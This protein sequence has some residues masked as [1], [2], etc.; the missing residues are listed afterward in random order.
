MRFRPFFDNKNNP[1]KVRVG[2]PADVTPPAPRL[3]N[4]D[5]AV[6]ELCG[7]IGSKVSPRAF[8]QMMRAHPKVLKAVRT[9]TGGKV[10]G[11]E[12]PLSGTDAYLDKL[13]DAW[14]GSHGFAHIYCGEPYRGKI[15]GLHFWGR[16][17]DLQEKQ[18][19]GRLLNNASREEVVPGAIYA[20]G[21]E[22]EVDGQLVRSPIKGYGLTLSAADILKAGTKALADNPT[23]SPRNQSCIL[24]VQD[25]GKDF[26]MVFVRKAKGIRTFFPD[27][28]PST[29]DPVC[30][31]VVKIR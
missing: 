5:R 15:G 18:L 11:H 12:R 19:G 6:N 29:S 1:E 27:A 21:V 20:V 26:K 13:T 9:F 28:T 3:D 7:P 4:F 16:Y 14:F 30:R 31:G 25:D 22:I 8:K 2:G 24:R 23:E 10:F 17:L